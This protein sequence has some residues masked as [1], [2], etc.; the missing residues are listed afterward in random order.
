M[1]LGSRLLNRKRKDWKQNEVI[2]R[3]VDDVVF[4]S[5]VDRYIVF[6]FSVI[7]GGYLIMGL[8]ELKTLISTR[9]EVEEF[10]EILGIDLI[11][12][13]YDDLDDHIEENA[14]NLLEYM[15]YE[16]DTSDD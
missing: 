5:V 10:V 2:K 4:I 1:V 3:C 15:D 13:L 8:D 7:A 14:K 11:D 12:L 9:L 6:N 16:I